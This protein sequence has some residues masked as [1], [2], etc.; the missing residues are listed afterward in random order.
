MDPVNFFEAACFRVNLGEVVDTSQVDG[1]NEWLHC[2][3]LA[4]RM[5]FERDSP[6]QPNLYVNRRTNK[7]LTLRSLKL[8]DFE[9][10]HGLFQDC[11]G[12]SMSEQHWRWKYRDADRLGIAAFENNRMVAF[13]GGM[14]RQL[15]AMGEQIA[16]IQVGDVMVHPDFR[17]SLSRKGPFQIVASTF[18]EQ[19]LS[20]TAPYQ[21][22]FGFPNRRAFKVAERL[23]LYRQAD[24]VVQLSWAPVNSAIPSWLKLVIEPAEA[25]LPN[26]HRVWA[27]M[28]TGFEA[29]ILGLRDA[30]YLQAR[31]IDAPTRYVWLGLRHRLTDQV[32]CI[33]ICKEVSDSLE[34]LDL[35][36]SPS[37]FAQTISAI[38]KHPSHSR[39]SK[40][41]MWVTKSHL[42]LFS[43]TRGTVTNLDI[44]V[45][46]NS[47][48]ASKYDKT[49]DHRWW[50]TG[51]DTDFR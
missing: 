48:V 17:T 16:G 14:P 39:F 36:G 44:A 45:P 29:S 40:I 27:E 8:D 47:W 34:I 24:E 33:A 12:H 21:L 26:V 19:N 1:S 18:L 25:L 30:Q 10:W 6:D 13:Y 41:F 43:K 35:V 11:F 3:A 50:L 2:D 32:V 49:V 37:Y 46:T 28:Q 20:R 38:R 31:Y 5:G 15:I 23:G 51:G 4:Q 7:S 42:H 22:G 9:S